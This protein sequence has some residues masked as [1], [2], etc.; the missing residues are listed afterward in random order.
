MLGPT[1]EQRPDTGSFGLPGAADGVNGRRACRKIRFPVPRRSSICECAA[2]DSQIPEPSAE[3]LNVMDV[4]RHQM[5]PMSCEGTIT[6]VSRHHIIKY[7]LKIFIKY[8]INTLH[9]RN[10]Y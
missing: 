2:R 10:Q 9:I 3:G 8:I 5:L 4:S 1:A 6:G 7:E